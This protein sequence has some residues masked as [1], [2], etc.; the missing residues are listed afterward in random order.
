MKK[1]III[2][3]LISLTGIL[4]RGSPVVTNNE[5]TFAITTGS[6][7]EFAIVVNNINLLSLNTLDV[8]WVAVESY[9][10]NYFTDNCIY[11]A[12]TSDVSFSL[13]LTGDT[14]SGSENNK[15]ATTD[16]SNSVTSGGTAVK[17]NC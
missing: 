11:M 15:N 6:G 8:E 9:L 5:N 13:A 12:A 4:S 17:K 7:N 1:L 3:M 14:I 2:V 10:P 16:K